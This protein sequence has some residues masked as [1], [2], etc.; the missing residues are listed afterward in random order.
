MYLNGAPLLFLIA[1]STLGVSRTQNPQ[2]FQR[3]HMTLLDNIDHNKCNSEM[4]NKRIS[5]TR[6]GCKPLNT[7]IHAP[8]KLIN[9]ACMAGNSY[10]IKNVEYKKSP[11][12]LR[13][14]TCR[15]SEEYPKD[16]KYLAEASS[17]KYIVISCDQNNQ[18]VHLAGTLNW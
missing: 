1:I 5:L 18:P 15:L 16:C 14:T 13:V 6:S 11:S 10:V 9:H 3:K 17:W 12:K 8:K 7:F 2:A 4:R